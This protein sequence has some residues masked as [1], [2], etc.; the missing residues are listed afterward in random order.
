M[1]S[2]SSSSDPVEDLLELGYLD[3]DALGHLPNPATLELLRLRLRKTVATIKS[4]HPLHT[5]RK[6]VNLPI[7]KLGKPWFQSIFSPTLVDIVHS[8]LRKGAYIHGVSEIVC[9]AGTASQHTHRDHEYGDG[10]SLVVAISLDG[11]ALKTELQPESHT[12]HAPPCTARGAMELDRLEREKKLVAMKGQMMIYDPHIMHRGGK[13]TSDV[14]LSNRVFIMM[15]GANTPKAHI[16]E[17]NETNATVGYK[18]MLLSKLV[19]KKVKKEKT[20]S[21]KRKKSNS[22]S[23]SS[24]KKK[25]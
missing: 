13:N 19:E 16:K 25:K 8:V 14:T 20:S 15:V 12:E 22:S 4:V 6:A 2:S 21:K 11:N 23:S 1:S 10:M 24:K 18:G 9:P 17:I 5:F 7:S 3:L